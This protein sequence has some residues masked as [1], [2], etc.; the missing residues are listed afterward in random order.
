MEQFI[1][2]MEM[3]QKGKTQSLYISN[4]LKHFPPFFNTVSPLLDKRLS[5]FL[6]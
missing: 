1:E 6:K 4:V 2:T 5:N 3:Q